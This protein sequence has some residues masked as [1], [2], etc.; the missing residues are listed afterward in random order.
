MRMS[1]ICGS[2][3]S[4]PSAS[5]KMLSLASTILNPTRRQALM[6]ALRI[7]PAWKSR[8]RI[9]LQTCSHPRVAYNSLL[10]KRRKEVHDRVGQ[11][12]EHIYAEHLEEFYEML[13]YHFL[14]SENYAKAAEY[15]KLA[16]KKAQKVFAFSDAIAHG[17][18]RVACLEKLP[19]TDEGLKK[20][21]DARTILALYFNHLDYFLEAKE[22]IA[23]IFDSAVNLDYKKRLGQLYL[24]RGM[25]NFYIMENSQSAIQDF[26][27]VLKILKK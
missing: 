12:I 15:Y 13:G 21:I 19:M 11:A 25:Y 6:Q 24:I 4:H 1:G 20:I 27:Q 16:G 5:T 17:R 23:P 2:S 22:A 9:H 18:N 10:L 3:A 7:A 26:E 14:M 8:G